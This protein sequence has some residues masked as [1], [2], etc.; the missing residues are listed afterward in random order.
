MDEKLETKKNNQQEKK[1][2]E[3]KLEQNTQEI[4]NSSKYK[5]IKFLLNI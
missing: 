4:I 1:Q 2:L 5:K 3:A